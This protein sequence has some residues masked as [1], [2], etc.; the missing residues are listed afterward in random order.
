MLIDVS[1]LVKLKLELLTPHLLVMI[2]MIYFW[3]MI[4]RRKALREK[5]PNKEFFSGPNAGK[6]RPEKSVFWHFAG[7]E[8]LNEKYEKGLQV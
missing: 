3:S 7:G 1:I 6:Y 5:C 4:D 8:V 2:M